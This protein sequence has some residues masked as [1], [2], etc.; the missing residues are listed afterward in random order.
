MA[1]EIENLDS[2]FFSTYLLAGCEAMA[3]PVPETTPKKYISGIIA[4]CLPSPWTDFSP[5]QSCAP[6]CL[7]CLKDHPDPLPTW[8]E[9][10]SF[11]KNTLHIY[12]DYGIHDYSK[13]LYNTGF[14]HNYKII[15]GADHYRAILDLVYSDIITCDPEMIKTINFFTSWIIAESIYNPEKCSIVLDKIKIMEPFLPE[16]R[17][18][19]LKT[20]IEQEEKNINFGVIF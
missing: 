2:P 13:I 15:Y 10:A 12:G 16:K 7:Y 5:G 8:G 20:W 3:R 11:D 17:K 19:L 1:K 6:D 4:L 14:D 18:F 9:G